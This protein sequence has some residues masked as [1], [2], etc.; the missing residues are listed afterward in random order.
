[1]PLSRPAFRGLFREGND[2]ELSLAL[3]QRIEAVYPG[4]FLRFGGLHE[5]HCR[6]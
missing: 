3:I 6:L 1:M 2:V 5:H 4:R